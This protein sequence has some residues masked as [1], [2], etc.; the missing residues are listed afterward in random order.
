MTTDPDRPTAERRVRAALLGSAILLTLGFSGPTVRHAAWV[1]VDFF[2]RD[3]ARQVVRH[4]RRYEAGIERGLAAPPAWRAATPGRLEEAVRQQIGRCRE[5]L[6]PPIPLADLVEELGVLAV[7]TLD[8]NDP[9][10]VVHA[11]EREPAYT[12]GY[13]RYVET[14]LDRVRDRKSVV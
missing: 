11:D 2:P 7:R 12:A 1:A 9:L 4:H 13:Q 5:S 8:L 3:L 14:I 10:A 6:R